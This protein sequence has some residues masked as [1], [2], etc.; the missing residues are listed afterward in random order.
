M[1]SSRWLFAL[2]PFLLGLALFVALVHGIGVTLIIGYIAQVGWGLAL[3][4]LT[5]G[6]RYFLRTLVWYFSIERGSRRL[7]LPTLF[8]IRLAGETIGELMFAGLVVGESTKAIAASRWLPGVSAYSSVFIENLLFGLSVVIFLAGG[9]LVLFLST[10]L[11]FPILVLSVILVV[12]LLTCGVILF[13]MLHRGWQVLSPLLSYF[14][15]KQFGWSSLERQAPQIRSFENAVHGFYRSHRNLFL[16]LMGLE[17]STHFIGVFEAWWILYMIHC[18]GTW[19]AAFLAESVNRL[20]N[21]FFSIIPLRLGVDEGG[22]ALVLESIGYPAAV[23]IS[24]AIIRKVRL[25][26]WMIPG[27]FLIGQ[28]SVKLGGSNSR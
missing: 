2:F 9:I 26:V 4:V 14:E 24:L 15:K 10:L 21:S 25:M 13:L 16:G 17:F 23:G 7:S 28:Y 5:C 8:N 19:L 18:Q 1:N 6:A 3:L 27:L 22:M 11:P 20:I 12:F